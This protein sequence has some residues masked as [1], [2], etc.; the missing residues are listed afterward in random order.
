MYA[1]PDKKQTINIVTLGCSK[2]VVDS[3]TLIRQ[4]ENNHL[5]VV[6]NE[7]SFEHK[8]VIINTCGFIRDAKQESV[9]T[10]L[11][12]IKAKEEGHIRHVYVMGCLSERY[13]PDLE[14][15]IPDVDKYFGVN[16]IDSIIEH[17]GLNYSRQLPG[18]RSLTTPSHYA[19]LKIS[20]GCDRSCAFCAIPLIRGRHI[21]RPMESLEAEA[22][23]LASK[24]VRELILIAQDLTWYGLDLYR[25][26]AL[27][28]LL[29]KLSEVRGIEWIRLHYAYPAGF[30]KDVIR[31]MKERDNICRY[32][33][34]PFQHASDK[35]L[36]GMRR[37]HTREQNYRLI[38]AIRSE[39]PGITLRTTLM[40]GHPGEGK[41]EFGE[42]LQFVR[43]IRFDR[44]GVFTYSEEEQTWAALHCKDSIPERE[45]KSRAD[46]L[47]LLQQQISKELNNNK[48]GLLLKVLIDGR[49]GEYFVGRSEADSPEVDHEVLVTATGNP[50]ETGEFYPVRINRVEEFDLYGSV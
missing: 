14:K 43:D 41:K 46:E 21:S 44:L 29:E 32:L 38:D 48:L 37:N 30:P 47:M 8:T 25:R 11:R 2:N 17:L 26:Q 20:E 6:H 49:E 40:T 13:K 36:S 19:Y 23:L 7:E 45:K 22:G 28:E 10:I 42:L 18:D 33:D 35:V 12:F 9:D 31:V 16:N 24:G 50:L 1:R 15:E 27:P 34:I 39:I 3:E 4:L 5:R